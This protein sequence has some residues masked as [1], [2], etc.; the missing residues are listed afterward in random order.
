VDRWLLDGTY[1]AAFRWI[2][3]GLN[4][5]FDPGSRDEYR[6]LAADAE[7][8]DAALE[9]QLYLADQQANFDW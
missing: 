2:R 5:A 4:V 9:R 8:L 6:S 1:E 7:K 3:A